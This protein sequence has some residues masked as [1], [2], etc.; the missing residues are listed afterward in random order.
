MPAGGV[1]D[2][3]M[4]TVGLVLSVDV[5]PPQAVMARHIAKVQ[6]VRM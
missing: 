4:D 6:T 2:D 3:E 1:S 5:P